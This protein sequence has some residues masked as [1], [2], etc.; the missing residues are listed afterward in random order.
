MS[1]DGSLL[2]LDPA[3]GAASA[4]NPFSSD[5]D[6]NR[7]RV[8]AYGMRNPFRFAFRPGTSEVWIGD[9]GSGTWEEI[10]RLVSPT[11]PATNFGWP[12]YEGEPRAPGFDSLN[13]NQCESLYAESTAVG[14]Y[15]SYN[16]SANVVAGESCTTG[17]S[18]IS[19]LAF[20]DRAHLGG[21]YP[22]AYD[23]ALFFADHSRNC[24]W[25]MRRGSNG[26]PDPSKIEAFD[27]P[28]GNPVDLEIGPGGDLYYVT[29]TEARSTGSSTHRPAM[30]QIRRPSP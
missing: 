10:D 22:A 14:P 6:P 15:Y 5:V 18:S 12:C 28:A 21:N 3:T 29:S 9:V 23:D 2:R 16:H 19:G 11:S 20:Y 8:V 27:A 30:P 24:I 1:L 13:L 26:L 4:L 7:R 25:A 17:R